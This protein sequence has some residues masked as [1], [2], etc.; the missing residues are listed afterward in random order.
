MV[1]TEKFLCLK[2]TQSGPVGQY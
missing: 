1:Y 2:N